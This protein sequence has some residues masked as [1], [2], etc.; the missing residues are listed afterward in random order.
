MAA[1]FCYVQTLLLP[2][3]RT[4]RCCWFEEPSE[5]HRALAQGSSTP[6]CRALSALQS[7]RATG[8]HGPAQGCRAGSPL[9]MSSPPRT[10]RRRGLCCRETNNKWVLVGFITY[11][12]YLGIGKGTGLLKSFLV[13]C[14]LSP[15]MEQVA[16][17]PTGTGRG[18]GLGRRS[19]L[20]FAT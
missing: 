9:W 2:F 14:H 7:R 18:S 16:T 5:T 4:R 6:H 15:S 1:F 3:L 8:D 19:C 20:H 17:C 12:F 13:V 10:P 11:L